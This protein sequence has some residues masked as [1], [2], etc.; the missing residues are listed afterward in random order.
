[1]TYDIRNAPT[2]YV[3]SPEARAEVKAAFAA[4]GIDISG[5]NVAGEW[6]RK[7]SQGICYINLHDAEFD[8]IRGQGSSLVK[9]LRPVMDCGILRPFHQLTGICNGCSHSTGGW[10]SW[11]NRFVMA[12]DCPVPREV[13]FLGAYLLGRN[14]LRGDSG[15]YPNYT[16][17]AYHDLGVLP[18]DCGGKYDLLNMTPEQQENLCV[19]MRDNPVFAREW[20]DAMAPLKTRV[21][22]PQ[23]AALVADSIA[24]YYPTTFGAGVQN[25]VAPANGG[26]SS[27]YSLGG[28]GHET[29][30]TGLAS[31]K[32]RTILLKTES[33][34]GMDG[35]PGKNFPG[36]RVVI[37]TDAGPKTL[38]PGQGAV[39]LDDWMRYGPECWAIGWPGSAA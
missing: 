6:Q 19:M 39:W 11:V 3:D 18:V 24:S 2:G 38:W 10:L 32:G 33:W 30:G 25:S 31:Y 21:N 9:S 14:G 20:L 35:F 16:C 22:S 28:Q 13:T 17:K 36:Y 23:G 26:I 15:A 7:L 34:F 37:M 12:G 29:C 4:S 1:M 27:I 8:F 5:E